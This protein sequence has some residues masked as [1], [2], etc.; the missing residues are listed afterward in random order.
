MLIAYWPANGKQ[1]SQFHPV[2]PRVR[3]PTNTGAYKIIAHT[4][5]G[6]KWFKPRKQYP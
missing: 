1:P 6:N 5:T 4:A 3:E 2:Q